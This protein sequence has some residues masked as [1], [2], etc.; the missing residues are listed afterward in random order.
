MSFRP[1]LP[2][3]GRRRPADSQSRG[4]SDFFYLFFFYCFCGHFTV[5]GVGI[6]AGWCG[7]VCGGGGCEGR[8]RCFVFGF[9]FIYFSSFF[10]CIF[11]TQQW[12][13]V[14]HHGAESA[15]RGA[16]IEST[17][18]RSFLKFISMKKKY[19][20]VFF[21]PYFSLFFVWSLL[22]KFFLFFL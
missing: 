7:V 10:F 18:G 15:R 19:S 5:A 3:I 1:W 22:F 21:L 11:R 9:S 6:G 2:L 4:E 20:D 17:A 12:R 8:R 16:E 13:L 14:N